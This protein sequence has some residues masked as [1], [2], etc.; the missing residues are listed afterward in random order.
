MLRAFTPI[1]YDRALAQSG[2][3]DEDDGRLS[4]IKRRLLPE[5]TA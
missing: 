5:M 4:T 2:F 1:L 3:A